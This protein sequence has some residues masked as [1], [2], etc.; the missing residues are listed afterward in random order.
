MRALV[1]EAYQGEDHMENIAMQMF[2]FRSKY[3]TVMLFFHRFV[4]RNYIAQSVI[5]AAENG[6]FSVVSTSHN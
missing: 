6:N 2:C 3:Q 4:L 1:E 5:E